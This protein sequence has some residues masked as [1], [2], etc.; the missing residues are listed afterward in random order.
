MLKIQ[1]DRMRISQ[2]ENENTLSILYNVGRFFKPFYIYCTQCTV[3]GI[4][5][6]AEHFVDDISSTVA[7][8]YVLVYGLYG[9]NYVNCQRDL[10][11]LVA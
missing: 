5:V 11:S 6:A 1:R 3:K 9:H 8:R 7:G 10:K 4:F 2:P